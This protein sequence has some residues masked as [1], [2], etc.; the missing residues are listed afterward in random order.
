MRP[1]PRGVNIEI[2]RLPEIAKAF[3][4]ALEVAEA[5]GMLRQGDERS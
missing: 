3:A 4:Q 5:E 2:E 1:T